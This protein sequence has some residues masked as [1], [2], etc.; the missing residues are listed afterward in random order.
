M[1][2]QR[3]KS[4]RPDVHYVTLDLS[5]TLALHSDSIRGRLEDLLDRMQSG[6]VRP[7]PSRSFKLS[8]ASNA[9]AWMQEGVNVGKPLIQCDD[10][11]EPVALSSPQ[12]GV[13]L[14]SGGLGGLGL[15]TS[16]Y[17]LRQGVHDIVLLT[18]REPTDREA[19]IL[20]DWNKTGARV[21]V[22]VMEIDQLDSV[23]STLQD[24][25]D[26]G[27]PI[28]AVYHLAGVL[29]DSNVSEQSVALFNTVLDPKAKGGWN[30][31]QATLDDPIEQFV[32]FSSLSGWL[33]SPGQANHATANAFLDSLAEFRRRQKLPAVSIGWGPWARVGSCLLYTSPSPRDLSTSR[34]PSSA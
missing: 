6:R 34:M 23:Q 28:T 17:L 12:P 3:I 5:Q 29:Q 21:R 1:L 24:I 7:L 8:E 14:I 16:D 9:F 4:I 33:G 25:R 10:L 32:L 13:H 22:Q 15:L 2:T 19:M 20:D 11:D 27:L 26:Q 30:L 18:R 31:H